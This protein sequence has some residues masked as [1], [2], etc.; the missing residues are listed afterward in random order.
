VLLSPWADLTCSGDSFQ[1]NARA[2]PFFAANAVKRAAAVAVRGGGD[3]ADWRLSPVFAPAERMAALPPMLLQAGSTEVLRDDA[4]RIA[5]AAAAGG[6]AVELQLFDRQPHVPPLYGNRHARLALR[7][8]G[9]F[10]SRVL[11]GGSP[12]PPT[13]EDVAVAAAS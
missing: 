10:V 3:P 4:V 8:I 9:Q 13:A 5:D 11:P 7:E 2:D 6:V 12:A 1:G